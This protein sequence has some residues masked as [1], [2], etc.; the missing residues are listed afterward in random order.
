[1][2]NQFHPGGVFEMRSLTTTHGHGHQAVYGTDRRLI[3]EGPGRGS[4]DKSAPGYPGFGILRH[5]SWDVRPFVWAA[6]LD[7]NPVNPKLFYEDLDARL[8]RAG[9]HID[10]YFS[11]RP[12]LV[13]VTPE[14]QIS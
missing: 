8:I 11:V 6:Q 13:G 3:R 10:R 1:M 9:E 4:A 12:A 7:G 14:V 5:V 2:H